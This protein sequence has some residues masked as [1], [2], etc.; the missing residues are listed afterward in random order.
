MV[1]LNFSFKLNGSK[2]SA[3]SRSAV[4]EEE[5]V[6]LA[7]TESAAHSLEVIFILFVGIACRNQFI[8]LILLDNFS[9]GFHRSWA[10]CCLYH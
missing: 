4:E 8:L 3:V 9:D 1:L 10:G 2:T 7:S 6:K 5:E